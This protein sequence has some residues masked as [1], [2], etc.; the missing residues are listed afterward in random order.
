ML[1]HG[2]DTAAASP[3]PVEALVGVRVAQVAFGGVQTAEENTGF[4][5]ARSEAGV[6]FSCGSPRRGR[7]GRAF[8]I[9]A[10]ALTEDGLDDAVHF[11]V[12]GEV[13]L[14]ADNALA[15]SIAAADNHAAALTVAGVP[16]VWGANEAGLLGLD[17]DELDAATAV[18]ITGLPVLTHVVCTAFSTAFLAAS[19]ELLLLG[20][21]PSV[22]RPRLAGLPGH[23]S[24]IFGGGHHLGVM[25]M[26]IK[27]G[28]TPAATATA[29]APVAP[30]PATLAEQGLDGSVDPGIAEML[31]D[32]CAGA[33]PLQLRHEL[34]LLR[35]LL[36]AERGK[37]H[38]IQHGKPMVSEA[39]QRLAE[40]SPSAGTWCDNAVSRLPPS[41][42]EQS[43]YTMTLD[44]QRA[45]AG[46]LLLVAKES[47]LEPNRMNLAE[48]RAAAARR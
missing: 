37:L 4:M 10:L 46:G 24:N 44:A 6:V 34:R 45:G 36:T 7:L 9:D 3:R 12:P 25:L 42:K 35:D 28:Q 41:K 38:E 16:Y 22:T 48:R 21:D 40:A 39:Q 32:D 18:E 26:G 2:S 33:T 23:I 30:K 29:E 31:L 27:P 8:S 14:G 11:G 47:I 17:P 15:S 5:L 13:Q 43:A 1:G 19:G 20:G